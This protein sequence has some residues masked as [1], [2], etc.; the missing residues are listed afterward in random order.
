MSNNMD[1]RDKQ[2][3]NDNREF[4][5]SGYEL[6]QMDMPG[7]TRQERRKVEKQAIRE[8]KSRGECEHNMRA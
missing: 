6:Y 3:I 2:H 7:S 1:Q 4:T 8:C 5:K